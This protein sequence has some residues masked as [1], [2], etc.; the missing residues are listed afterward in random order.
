MCA[1]IELGMPLTS[2]DFWCHAGF[3]KF[4]AFRVEAMKGLRVRKLF[5][6]Q[7]YGSV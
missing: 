3:Q 6:L 2:I 5:S 1:H 7:I 4:T